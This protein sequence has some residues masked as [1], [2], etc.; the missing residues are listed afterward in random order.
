MGACC[1]KD[2]EGCLS[3]LTFTPKEKEVEKK[4]QFLAAYFV[5]MGKMMDV[6]RDVGAISMML[7]DQLNETI[8]LKQKPFKE[9][10]NSLI[11]QSFENHDKNKDGFLCKEEAKCFFKHYAELY[12]RFQEK[13][14]VELIKFE[15]NN[16]E[17]LRGSVG[18]QFGEEGLSGDEHPSRQDLRDRM[19]EAIEDVKMSLKERRGYYMQNKERL[20]DEAFEVV[21]MTADGLIEYFELVEAFTIDRKK[22]KQ[23]LQ[24]LGLMPKD[25]IKTTCSPK[26]CSPKHFTH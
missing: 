21:D 5:E 15:F 3:F 14:E 22:H 19:N 4:A 24:A 2:G 8:K 25:L 7:N 17:E 12:C 1:S 9:R 18:E 10:M 20:D 11:L 23:V 26:H 16:D 6:T 13:Y